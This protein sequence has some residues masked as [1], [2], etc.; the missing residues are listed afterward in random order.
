MADVAQMPIPGRHNSVTAAIGTASNI[1]EREKLL[2]GVIIA[3]AE[4]GLVFLSAGDGQPLT[5]AEAL[6]L[7]ESAK[8]LLMG[9][10]NWRREP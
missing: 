8:S 5:S 9:W 1:A 4:D 7:L 3:E 2:R 6:W 10:G